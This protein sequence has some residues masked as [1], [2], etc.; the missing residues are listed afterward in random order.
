MTAHART[1]EFEAIERVI[2]D[3]P[4]SGYASSLEI[5]LAAMKCEGAE[6][7][8]CCHWSL[9][10]SPMYSQRVTPHGVALHYN[11][12]IVWDWH[13]RHHQRLHEQVSGRL[14]S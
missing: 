12:W 11:E 14:S 7:P 8:D 6:C 5:T 4:A 9:P 10:F 1:S 2:A 13:V 3:A